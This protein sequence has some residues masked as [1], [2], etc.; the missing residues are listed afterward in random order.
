MSFL[1]STFIHLRIIVYF[2][3][4]IIVLVISFFPEGW[5]LY[6]LVTESDLDMIHYLMAPMY[7]FIAYCLTVLFF[8]V[9]HSQIVVR[10]LL[11]FRIKP[12]IYSHHSAMGR[13]VGVRITADSIFKAMLKVFT[14]FP[15]IWGILLF[16][17]GM[18]LYGLKCGKNVHI[19]TRT[20]VDTAG[21]VEIG[22]NAFIGYNCVVTGHTHEN[23]AIIVNPTK[24][25]RKALVGAYSIVG[26]GCELGDSAVLGAMSGLPKGEKIPEGEVWVGTP[27][28]F[29]RRR[30][31]KQDQQEV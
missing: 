24:I 28:K 23:R 31:E 21:L 6:F 8:G 14:F 20:Y 2:F 5:L 29:L 13:L 16:P 12:G 18:R 22:N 19:T 25:G 7:L 1:R 17:Y 30:G 9:V 15:F 10:F 27:A 3:L 11:T 26:P 4:T